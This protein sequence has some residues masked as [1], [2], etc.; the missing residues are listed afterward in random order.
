[1]I[2]SSRILGTSWKWHCHSCSFILGNGK[3]LSG[4]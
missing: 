1:M 4:K 2:G 3:N